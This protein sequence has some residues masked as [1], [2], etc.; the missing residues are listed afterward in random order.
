VEGPGDCVRG[1]KEERS[2]P[3]LCPVLPE[4][5]SLARLG[6]C[7]ESASI[8]FD[9]L[10]QQ[11]RMYLLDHPDALRSFDSISISMTSFQ[12]IADIEGDNSRT[13]FIT[14]MFAADTLA[15][16]R[17]LLYFRGRP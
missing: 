7:L 1:E 2:L 11:I 14:S 13:T 17:I 16:L 8:C 6:V 10:K 3:N 15:L 4:D 12:L 9:I 5:S